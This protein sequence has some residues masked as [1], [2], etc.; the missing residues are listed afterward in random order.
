[1]T[2]PRVHNPP[3]GVKPVATRKAFGDALKIV[4][5]KDPKIVVLDVQDR[6]DKV[7]AGTRWAAVALLDNKPDLAL[8][9]IKES[10]ASDMPPDLITQR[11]RLQGRALFETGDTLQGL[12]LVRDDN[13]LDGL[14]LKADLQWRLREWPAAAAA[15][16][17]GFNVLAK[18]EDKPYELREAHLVDADGYIWV[19]DIPVKAQADKEK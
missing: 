5:D 11:R 6:L 13:S 3:A 16:E 18:A 15:L 10:E 19:P 4:G 7:R 12:S 14:W 2:S 1:M 17:H 8:K 9:A